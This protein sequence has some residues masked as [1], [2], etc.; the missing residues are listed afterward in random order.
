MVDFVNISHALKNNT[1]SVHWVESLTYINI[2][3]SLYKYIFAYVSCLANSS[4]LLRDVLKSSTTVLEFSIFCH[5]SSSC[6][7]F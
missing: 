2:S 7:M 5:S 6:Y 1:F 4:L 3:L